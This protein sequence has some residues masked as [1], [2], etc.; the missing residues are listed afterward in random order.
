MNESEPKGLAPGRPRS[1]RGT[2]ASETAE[3]SA[4][5]DDVMASVVGLSELLTCTRLTEKGHVD[6]ALKWCDEQ[7]FEGID[8]ILRTQM[9][10]DF[11]AAMGLKPGK[12]KLLQVEL[13][14]LADA[15]K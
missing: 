8:E 2:A 13:Q 5:S 9:Q 1:A 14:K 10:A 12:Q 4:A 3:M 15:L 7:G 11:I 6:A